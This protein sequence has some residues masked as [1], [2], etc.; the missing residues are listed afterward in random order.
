AG[1]VTD[2]SGVYLAGAVISADDVRMRRW[3]TV[4][5][6][7]SG[8]TKW[9]NVSELARS[10]APERIIVADGAV[11][12]GGQ[13]DMHEAARLLLIERRDP[14]SGKRVWQR[15]FTARD[16]K[17]VSAG[18]AGKDTFGGISVQG[19]SVL[20]VATVD[21]PLEEAYGELSLGKGE[22]AKSYQS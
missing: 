13:D 7:G 10:P 17:C 1:I 12:V 16:A 8:A 2:A 3:A 21:R 9:S 20:Y 14:T 22:P 4:K 5:L 6:D 19:S 15:R 18:C 11:I